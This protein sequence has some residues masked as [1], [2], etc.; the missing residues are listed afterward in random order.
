MQKPPAERSWRKYVMRHACLASRRDKTIWVEFYAGL[1]RLAE[2]NVTGITVFM[3]KLI[4][5]LGK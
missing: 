4:I 3:C 2:K 1:T 5:I